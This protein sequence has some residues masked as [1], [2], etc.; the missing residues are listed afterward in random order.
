MKMY[1]NKF[2]IPPVTRGLLPLLAILFSVL[3]LHSESAEKSIKTNT[4]LQQNKSSIHV[5]NYYAHT[6]IQS[7]LPYFND[8]WALTRIDTE[9]KDS[10]FFL[11]FH[12]QT[13]TKE[14]L[15]FHAQVDQT[16]GNVLRMVDIKPDTRDEIA[17]APSGEIGNVAALKLFLPDPKDFRKRETHFFRDYDI[18]RISKEHLARIHTE[19]E[20]PEQLIL[21]RRRITFSPTVRGEGAGTFAYDASTGEAILKMLGDMFQDIS[22]AFEPE[23]KETP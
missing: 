15:V 10:D 9:S 21:V 3:T 6:A 14:P 12:F 7:I 17:L 11:R 19:I 20:Y 16:T 5:I 22:R 23:H 18:V 4:L 8:A 13:I 2:Q 1:K